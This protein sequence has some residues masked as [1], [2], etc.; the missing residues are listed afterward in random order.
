MNGRYER[1]NFL[2]QVG[3]FSKIMKQP[4]WRPFGDTLEGLAS[5]SAGFGAILRR[6]LHGQ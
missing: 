6:T 3:F 5:R 2:K 1:R 4:A